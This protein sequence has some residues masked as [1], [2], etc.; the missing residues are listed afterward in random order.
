MESESLDPSGQSDELIDDIATLY[1]RHSVEFIASMLGVDADVVRTSVYMAIKNGDDIG[2][3]KKQH[4]G[5]QE[6][7]APGDQEVG[8]LSESC[9]VLHEGAMP[10]RG[11]QAAEQDLVSERRP[12]KRQGE[13]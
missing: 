10:H 9:C 2:P 7:A 8:H 5:Q 13:N 6:E 12:Q 1:R 11:I 4:E 3:F